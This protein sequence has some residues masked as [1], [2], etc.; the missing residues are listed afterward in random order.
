MARYYDPLQ[1]LLPYN[2]HGPRMIRRDPMR[3]LDLARQ[4]P[5]ATEYIY[6]IRLPFSCT[7]KTSTKS[8]QLDLGLF[9]QRYHPYSH[10]Q[11]GLDLHR[12]IGESSRIGRGRQQQVRSMPWVR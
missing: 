10:P 8:V 11:Y 9:T 12:A 5:C 1:A 4:P 7:S 6:C 3:G 2:F